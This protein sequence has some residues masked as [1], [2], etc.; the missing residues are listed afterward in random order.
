MFSKDHRTL[1]FTEVSRK[2]YL[3]PKLGGVF[4]ADEFEAHPE[5]YR[6][7]FADEVFM[8]NLQIIALQAHVLLNILDLQ[9]CV[10]GIMC[11]NLYPEF[12][13]F[14]INLYLA[15]QGESFFP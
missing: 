7:N 5:R 3:V 2:D 12:S 14:H 4:N 13:H 11:F 9:V 6:S 15:G 10:Y 1:V 8:I